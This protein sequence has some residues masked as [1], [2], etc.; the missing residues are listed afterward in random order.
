M[1]RKTRSG[2]VPFF[3]RSHFYIL[4]LLLLLFPFYFVIII[5]NTIII[6]IIIQR[7]RFYR[8]FKRLG[9]HTRYVKDNAFKLL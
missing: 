9:L 8:Q 3:S 7:S 6:T 2:F 5:V 1:L 4:L